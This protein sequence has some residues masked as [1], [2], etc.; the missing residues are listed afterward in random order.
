MSKKITTA[1]FIRS[2]KSRHGENFDYSRAVYSKAKNK[3][4]IICNS[5]GDIFLQ[6]ACSHL[7]GVGCPNCARCKIGTTDTFIKNALT[8]HGG[9]FDYSKVV[10]INSHT[11]VR[12]KC[13][14]CNTE[15]L[16]APTTHLKNKGCGN[17]SNKL[18]SS[19][20]KFIE[21]A[22]KVHGEKYDY[23]LTD[24]ENRK[25]KVYI[26]CIQHSRYF[27]KSPA[28]H[29]KGQ[30]CPL[31]SSSGFK[32]N[33]P[34]ILYYLKV[35]GL[36]KI[37]ITNR[38]ID[39]RFSP[40]D[41]LQIKVLKVWRYPLGEDALNKEQEILRKFKD[42]LYLGA[43]ILQSGNTELFIYDILGLDNEA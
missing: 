15:F 6:E 27:E 4:E 42:S 16:Q 34:A 40:M 41:L 22:R 12:I 32:I 9:R 17:C 35:G 26:Y 24:Y 21:K 8:K 18:K 3:I 33:K 5:C 29:L 13:N 36:F 30:G 43:P 2:A 31:C 19:T 1:D 39:A 28:N 10:Y 14:Y 7:Q 23:T 20:S 38:T 37:G 11:H 25:E